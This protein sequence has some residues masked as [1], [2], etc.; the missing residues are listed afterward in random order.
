MSAWGAVL[1]RHNPWF[2][3]SP[4]RTL[5]SSVYA[6]QFG[7]PRDIVVNHGCVIAAAHTSPTQHF[8]TGVGCQ[9]GAHVTVDISGGVSI[10]DYV[11]VSEGAMIFTHSHRVGKRSIRWRDQGIDYSHLEIG[12]DVWI[13][14]GAIVLPSV[15]RISTGAIIAAGAVVSKDV[16]DY[17][18]V[19]G[20][21]ARVIQ[22]RSD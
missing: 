14:A 9:L 15:Q 21:P 18:V 7:V 16:P 13:G 2:D 3:Y 6:K 10:G 4:L 8:S 17:A 22:Y 12:D 20:V 1:L 19:A 11:T 5:K